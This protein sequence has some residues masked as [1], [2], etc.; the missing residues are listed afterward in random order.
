MVDKLF[1]YY[2]NMGLKRARNNEITLA[3]E[4]LSIAVA[5]KGDNI[6]AW[7]LLGLCYYR[8]GKLPTA[9][10]CWMVSLYVNNQDN[11]ASEY[12]KSVKE[13]K[14]ALEDCVSSITALIGER[15]YKKALKVLQKKLQ[16][17][18]GFIRKF[19][20][21][22]N[23]TDE[24]DSEINDNVMMLNYIGLLYMLSGK[25]KKALKA[26]GKALLLDA[27]NPQALMY[28]GSF[29]NQRK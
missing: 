26:W 3:V 28:I 4:A 24:R 20:L 16:K 18:R 23:N 29:F 21:K 15:E 22:N 27:A 1:F 6:Y 10:Y 19:I 11:P 2:Y 25:R 17:S 8:L 7:N 12:I 13:E 5:L 14:K 9:E